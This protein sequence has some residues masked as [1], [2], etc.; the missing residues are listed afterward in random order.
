M[1]HLLFILLLFTWALGASSQ[2][3]LDSTLWEK[4]DSMKIL[5]ITPVKN[6]KK[7]LKLVIER[8]H[9][10]LQETHQARRYQIEATFRNNFRKPYSASCIY[11]AEGDN[12]LEITGNSYDDSDI[13]APKMENFCYEGPYKLHLEDSISMRSKLLRLLLFSP[14]HQTNRYPC[15]YYPPSP[16]VYYKESARWYIVN[17]YEIDYGS[18]R[19][20]YRIIL[21][22]KTDRYVWRQGDRHHWFTKTKF[23]AYFDRNTL[24]IT[25]IR[26]DQSGDKTNYMSPSNGTDFSVRFQADYDEEE[27]MPVLKKIRYINTNGYLSIKGTVRR[28]DQ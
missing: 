23:T 20:A 17:A 11:N 28:I 3:S 13:N 24:R 12:G 18:D 19:G 5:S 8:L 25:Q 7:L 27:G 21:D 15:M 2:V 26:G 6:P 4:E 22:K 1:K 14:A 9:K 16:F 10:D